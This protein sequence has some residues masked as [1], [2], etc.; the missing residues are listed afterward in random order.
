M[1]AKN[2]KLSKAHS[3]KAHVT[4]L[5]HEVMEAQEENIQLSLRVAQ[6]EVALRDA[7]GTNHTA[8]ARS[9]GIGRW[10]S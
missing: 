6:L 9:S 1:V 2:R 7:E 5:E 3:E 4:N 8:S 10:R